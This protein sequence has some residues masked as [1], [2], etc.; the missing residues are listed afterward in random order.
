MQQAK[1]THIHDIVS[2]MFSDGKVIEKCLVAECTH[3][4]KERR[5]ILCNERYESR[6]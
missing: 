5:E 6:Q 3:G 2:F 1:Q 4:D